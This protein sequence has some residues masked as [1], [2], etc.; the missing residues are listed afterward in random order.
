MGEK[1]NKEWEKWVFRNKVANYENWRET[2]TFKALTWWVPVK[3]LGVEVSATTYKELCSQS[4]DGIRFFQF[5]LELRR[6]RLQEKKSRVGKE[7]LS[8]LPPFIFFCDPL[9]KKLLSHPTSSEEAFLL[10]CCKNTTKTTPNSKIHKTLMQSQDSIIQCLSV[11][12]INRV[13]PILLH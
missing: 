10:G 6:R 13:H 7:I 4:K 3:S 5:P 12:G 9:E 2:P 1:T 8:W 11:F